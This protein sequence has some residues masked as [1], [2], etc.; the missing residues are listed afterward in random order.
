V[1]GLHS[2]VFLK[3]RGVSKM[4]NSKGHYIPCNKSPNPSKNESPIFYKKP[5]YKPW[6]FYTLAIITTMIVAGG[7][8]L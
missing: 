8:L 5:I 4:R 6:A 7:F 2:P 3:L 1:A